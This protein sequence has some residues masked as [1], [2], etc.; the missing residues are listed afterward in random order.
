[1]LDG[2]LLERRGVPAAVILT[3]VFGATGRAMAAAH[4]ADAFDWTVTPHPISNQSPEEL[5]A[6]ARRVLGDV[7][8]L[9]T[10]P[11]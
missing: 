3:D 1:M 5:R 8:T 6:A 4:G 9:L 10:G 2:I 7:V 11:P